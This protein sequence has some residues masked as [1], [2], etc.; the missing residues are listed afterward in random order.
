MFVVP[1]VGVGPERVPAGV[2]LRTALL[3]AV[4]LLA[5]IV[6][7]RLLVNVPRDVL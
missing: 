1:L 3:T 5:G 7:K 4:L 2:P 6:P